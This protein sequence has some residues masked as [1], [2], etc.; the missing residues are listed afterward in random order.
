M[1][2]RTYKELRDALEKIANGCGENNKLSGEALRLFMIGIGNIAR[3][4]LSEATE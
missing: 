2:G 1:H 3:H 4:A